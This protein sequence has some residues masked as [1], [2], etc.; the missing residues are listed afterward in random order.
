MIAVLIVASLGLMA[1]TRPVPDVIKAHEFK[2]VDAQG[3][4]RVIV[5]TAHGPSVR[6]LDADG[7]PEVTMQYERSS[8]PGF[9][10]GFHVSPEGIT[11]D[12]QITDKGPRTPAILVHGITPQILLKDTK[13]FA[14]VL[15]STSTVTPTTGTTQEIPADS[16]IMLGNN[17]ERHVI[18]RA[19]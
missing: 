17:K 6:L 3:T 19:P 18:W 4:A 15:R 14:M 2:A 13:G 10:L 16:I 9:F 8:V 5:S 1:A 7:L 12:V 11:P